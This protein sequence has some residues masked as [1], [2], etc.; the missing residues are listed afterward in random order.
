MYLKHITRQLRKDPVFFTINLVGLTAGIL[1]FLLMTVILQSEFGYDKFH[2][3]HAQAYRIQTEIFENNEKMEA[4]ITSHELAPLLAREYPYIEN[5]VRFL[6]LG[7]VSVKAEGANR[8]SF[9][10]SDILRADSSVFSVFTHEFITGNPSN[11]LDNQNSIVLTEKLA[12]K[13]FGSAS[14]AMNKL[15]TVEEEGAPKNN[16]LVS[17]VIADLPSNSHLVFDALIGGIP[18]RGMENEDGTLN[19]GRLFAIDYLYSYVLFQKGYD[20]SQFESALNSFYE[21]Y[22]RPEEELSEMGSVMTNSIKPLADLHFSDQE[23]FGDMPKG[24]SDYMVAFSVAVVL[25]LLMTAFNYVNLTS[26]RMIKR[27]KAF[28]IRKLSGASDGHL[29]KLVIS[30]SVF[31]FFFAFLVALFLAYT[32]LDGRYIQ[33]L[34]NINFEIDHFFTTEFY[35][36]AFGFVLLLGAVSGIYP[37]MLLL[38][39]L[40]FD[41]NSIVSSKTPP[42]RQVLTTLQF[43]VSLVVVILTF[44]V[45]RQLNHLSMR[46]LGFT[47]ENL[48]VIKLRDNDQLS[49]ARILSQRL[50]ENPQISRSSFVSSIAG[51]Q[52]SMDGFRLFN[53]NEEEN[54][55]KSMAHIKVS[56][57]YL[58]TMEIEYLQK[59]KVGYQENDAFIKYVVINEKAA[60]LLQVE[61]IETDKL[62]FIGSKDQINIV[63]IVKD[64]H[65]NSLHNEVE[66]VLLNLTPN[67]QNNLLVKGVDVKGKRFNASVLAAWQEVFPEAPLEI[68]YYDNLL[69][70]QYKEDIGRSKLLISFCIWSLIIALTGF[71]GLSTYNVSAQLRQIMIRRVIGASG[72]DVITLLMKENNIGA[73]IAA[74]IALPASFYLFNYWVQSYAYRISFDFFSSVGILLAFF[75]IL[76]AIVYIVARKTLSMNPS[77]VLK[78]E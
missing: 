34:A 14:E 15:L 48:A 65:Y 20:A 12:K 18:D 58:E 2:E 17:A 61:N 62:A 43:A 66:P 47:S 26:A 19:N 6:K 22:Y 9:Y 55:W 36:T 42:T 45:Y 4:A 78:S 5:Y 30:E 46:D 39:Y 69:K 23:L 75:I 44:S 27:A 11:S 21:K 77:L 49:K 67:S 71:I 10:E 72:K 56:P 63:G 29:M 37:A 59:S 54:V 74:C 51:D 32:I 25:I 50:Q 33:D 7:E 70:E 57:E 40:R 76:T 28:G 13:Y 52:P 31:I 8:E 41:I 73:I 24:N 53:T 68:S 60:Q 16:Y 64:Y 3:K 38:K 1:V 35:L